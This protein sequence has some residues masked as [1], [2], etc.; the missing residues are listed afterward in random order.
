MTR[1]VVTVVLAVLGI[2]TGT[3]VRS[4]VVEILVGENGIA[5]FKLWRSENWRLMNPKFHDSTSGRRCMAFVG[6]NTVSKGILYCGQCT[7][8]AWSEGTREP[9]A[10]RIKNN[11]YLLSSK[12]IVV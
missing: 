11:F 3:A 12:F 2:L 7:H 6:H 4:D 9:I 1:A 8:D 5:A 10:M